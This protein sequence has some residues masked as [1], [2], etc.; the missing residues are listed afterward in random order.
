MHFIILGVVFRNSL[1][2]W[3]LFFLDVLTKLFLY[4]FFHLAFL[5]VWN[6]VHLSE[7]ALFGLERGIEA[8]DVTGGDKIDDACWRKSIDL[9][10]QDVHDAFSVIGYLSLHLWVII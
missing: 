2:F 1:S 8:E 7:I 4:Q 9:M 3:G 6:S 5:G 10:A